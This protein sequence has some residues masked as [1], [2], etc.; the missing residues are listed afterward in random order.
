M[1]IF[2]R[3]LNWHGPTQWRSAKLCTNRGRRRES[4]QKRSTFVAGPWRLNNVGNP[5]SRK[6][7]LSF[8]V[9]FPSSCGDNSAGLGMASLGA[10]DADRL[11]CL[12]TSLRTH[13]AAC[14]RLLFSV[15]DWYSERCFSQVAA[16]QGKNSR[17]T[18][19]KRQVGCSIR[20]QLY[21]E[22][23]QSYDAAKEAT[24]AVC[25]PVLSSPATDPQ[26]NL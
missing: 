7:P 10:V 9:A 23:H 12:V 4:M 5:E 1:W 16:G 20:R 17:S 26:S 13:C 18:P 22:K 8:S 2:Q 21:E 19:A 15:A 6:G 24:A 25:H 11:L 3:W 14:Q